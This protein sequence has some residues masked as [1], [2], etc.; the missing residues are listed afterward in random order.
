M[1]K[2][3]L[4]VEDIE[5]HGKFLMRRLK[6]EGYEVELAT[7]VET[8]IYMAQKGDISLIILDVMLPK[9]LDDPEIDGY[10]GF[11]I[12]EGIK[13]RD[14]PIIF[15]TVWEREEEYL[16]AKELG[17]KAYFSKPYDIEELLRKIREIL[18]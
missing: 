18:Q 3:I 10:G 13:D 12:A 9:S 7:D 14:I 15:T 2:T 1:N 6:N 17:M 11:R 4:V 5:S 16:R 8:G